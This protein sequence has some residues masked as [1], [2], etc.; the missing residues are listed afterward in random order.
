[1]VSKNNVD[2][3]HVTQVNTKIIVNGVLSF[4]IVSSLVV[5]F[6]IFIVN[7]SLNSDLASS[8]TVF[9]LGFFAV[10]LVS[11]IYC[12]YKFVPVLV[13]KYKKNMFTL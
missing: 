9:M 4:I 3:D 5:L 8:V 12:A 6:N 11:N 7:M 2:M 1:M 13:N 10:M